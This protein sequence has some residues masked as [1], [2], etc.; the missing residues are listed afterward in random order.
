MVADVCRVSGYVRLL[1]DFIFLSLGSRLNMQVLIQLLQSLH[2]E[3]SLRG[4]SSVA[5]E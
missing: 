5:G 4:A 2:I 3:R 1:W